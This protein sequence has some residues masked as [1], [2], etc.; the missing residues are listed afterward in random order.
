MNHQT[1]RRLR[2]LQFSL[3]TM[4]VVITAL[5]LPIACLAH[6]AR[7]ARQY[8]AARGG[9]ELH[10]GRM[11]AFPL[12]TTASY[13]DRGRA[14]LQGKLGGPN[15]PILV[16]FKTHSELKDEDLNHVVESLLSLSN[17]KSFSIHG[18]DVTDDGVQCLTRLSSLDR[19]SLLGTG[20]TDEGAR[21]LQAALP[22]CEI[23]V[24]P[25]VL[26]GTVGGWR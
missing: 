2:R 5:T 21:T 1:K 26:C 4:L 25:L 23:E 19:I 8:R 6:E 22:D 9:L 12:D 16:S 14:W 24:G 20:V 13:V 15:G 3:K 11:Y 10:H 7:I 17:V 18:G